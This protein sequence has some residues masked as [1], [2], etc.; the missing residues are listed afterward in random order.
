MNDV[1]TVFSKELKRFWIDKKLLFTSVLL[2]GIMI[3]IIYS[4]MGNVFAEQALETETTPSTVYIQHLPS[5]YEALFEDTLFNV[6]PYDNQDIESLIETDEAAVLL[7][8]EDFI[9]ALENDAFPTVTLYYS[10]TNERSNIAGNRVNSILSAIRESML[11]SRF[12][13]EERLVFNQQNTIFE[14]ESDLF[15]TIVSG[16]VPLL[17]IIFLFAGALSIGPDVIA[18]EKERGTLATLLVTPVSRSAFAIG[19]IL[20]ISV[21]SLASA[22]SSFIGIAFSL[23][24]LLQLE[25]STDVNIFEIYGLSSIVALLLTLLVT[26]LLI[27]GLISVVSTYAKSVKEAA[28]LAS[29]LYLITIVISA[30]NIFSDASSRLYIFA[31]PLFGPIQVI[32]SILNQSMNVL[33]VVM[34]IVSHLLW[35]LLLSVLVRKMLSS[36]RIVFQK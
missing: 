30:L 27:V 31:I 24:R 28:S 12:S 4:V 10:A 35:T 36:E 5:A 19:K 20:A 34:V 14:D 2:P 21:I 3:Y 32:N 22:F 1:I 15:V 7:F 8:E 9:A 13:D 17:I 29:P 6:Q 16:F 26:T 23:P 18:G 25:Q 11:S 33:E